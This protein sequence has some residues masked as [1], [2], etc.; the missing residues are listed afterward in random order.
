MKFRWEEKEIQTKDDV[1]D[2]WERGETIETATME[3]VRR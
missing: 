1:G 2:S 3:D